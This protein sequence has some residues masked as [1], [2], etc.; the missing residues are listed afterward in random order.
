[1]STSL[2]TR[3]S[4]SFLALLILGMG[5]AALLAWRLVENLYLETQRE[6][7]LAQARLTAAVLQGQ[8]LPSELVEPYLQTAN[9]QPGIHTRLLT[10]Q[11]AV[12]VGVPLA[13]AE[14][15]LPS[16]ENLATISPVELLKRQEIASALQGQSA[17]AVR[18]VASAGGRRVLYA[19]APVLGADGQ[20]SGLVYLATPLPR[21]GLPSQWLLALAGAVSA[22]ILLASLAG[23]WLARRIARPLEIIARAADE[24][25]RGDLTPQVQPEPTVRELYSLGMAF[26]RMTQSLRQSEQVKSAF[27]ADVT[28]EL[29]TPLTVIKGTLETLQDGALDDAEGRGAL[30]DSMQRELTICSCWRVP[31]PVRSICV[32]RNSTWQ[33]WHATAARTWLRWRRAGK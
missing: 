16:V 19:A 6:N 1:M 27:V 8:P 17:S 28:H 5:A 18:R 12:L 11:G 4:L 33:R 13:S 26:N 20:V 3:L 7:L 23:A 14:V 30:L 32:W 9:A 2:R 22:A 21:A 31:M 25:S 15:Q 24:V 10:E 29:R